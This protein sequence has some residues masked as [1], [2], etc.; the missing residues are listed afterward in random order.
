VGTPA[1]GTGS[2]ALA[3]TGTRGLGLLA[4]AGTTAALLGLLIRRLARQMNRA[5]SIGLRSH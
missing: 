5:A 4:G 2:G 1:R 3:F